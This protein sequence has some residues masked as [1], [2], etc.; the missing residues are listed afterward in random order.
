MIV[1]ELR[2]SIL[3]YAFRGNLTEHLDSD[4]NVDE[5]LKSI[6]EEKNS[7]IN[8]GKPNK[9]NKEYSP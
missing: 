6:Y 7:L 5:L 9:N 1:D 2:K 8:N 4:S 3:L